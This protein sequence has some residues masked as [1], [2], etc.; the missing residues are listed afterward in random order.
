M[1]MAFG[2]GY[3]PGRKEVRFIKLAEDTDANW[4]AFFSYL[5]SWNSETIH[6]ASMLQRRGNSDELDD[7]IFKDALSTN[8][9]GM[10]SLCTSAAIR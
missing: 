2:Y 10:S 9:L 8:Y 6:A 4:H 3:P 7:K 1:A 5:P